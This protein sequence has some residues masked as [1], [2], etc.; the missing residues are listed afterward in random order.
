LCIFFSYLVWD[1]RPAGPVWG[2]SL[3]ALRFDLLLLAALTFMVS[4]LKPS[5]QIRKVLMWGAVIGVPVVLAI[6]AQ[7]F[8]PVPKQ[9]LVIGVLAWQAYGQYAGIVLLPRYGNK[10]SWLVCVVGAVC[11]VLLVRELLV[12]ILPDI[13]GWALAEVYMSTAVLYALHRSRT[14]LANLIGIVG[15]VIWGAFYMAAMYLHRH[16]QAAFLLLYQYWN[17]P[18]YFVAFS[19]ILKIPE[20]AKD[21]EAR[22]ADQYESMYQDFR[23]MFDDNPQPVLIYAEQT[24]QFLL[25]NRAAVECYGYSEEEF[26][27]RRI[28]D[29]EL[30]ADDESQAIEAV[31]PAVIEGY[32]TRVRHRDGH[33]MWVTFTG[34]S[35]RY[36]ETDAQLV[37]VRDVTKRVE[38]DL[39]MLQLANHDVLTGL[40]NRRLLAD[41]MEH[42]LERSIRDDRK[43]AVFAIDIDHFKQVNDT[44]GHPVGDSCLKAVAERLSSKIRTADTLARIG[45]EEFMAVIGGLGSMA[46][47]ERIAQSLLK[48]FQEPL[49]LTECELGVTVSIGVAVFP[50]DSYDAEGLYKIADAALYTAKQTGRNRYVVARNLTSRTTQSAAT[51][52]VTARWSDDANSG[53]VEE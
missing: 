34:H 28:E 21:E 35:I 29:F 4:F 37:I 17:F 24:G 15:F 19:M 53:F 26:L 23:L 36:K 50:D 2:S 40:P 14:S 46:D 45:G 10:R 44:Y 3:N 52:G 31:L 47:A 8:M 11:G 51:A 33:W 20:D 7:E 32:R 1:L 9:V 38:A 48:L 30:P 5:V 22:L 18:K 41:R 42:S 12:H 13:K 39:E 27:S 25:A 16:N 6:N 49:Q 43:T